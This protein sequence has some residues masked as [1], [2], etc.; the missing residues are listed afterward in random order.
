MAGDGAPHPPSCYPI[1][2]PC[3]PEWRT[4]ATPARF[5][6]SGF[7]VTTLALDCYPPGPV[8]LFK[9]VCFQARSR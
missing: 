6:S 9:P 7:F 1:A 8:G 4:G 5:R 2:R 3:W